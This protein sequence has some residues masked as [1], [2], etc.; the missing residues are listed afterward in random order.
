MAEAILSIEV[1]TGA[2][3]GLPVMFLTL[4]IAFGQH[5]SVQWHSGTDPM[6]LLR[7]GL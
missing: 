5:W 7:Q 4:Q 3:L 6:P 1:N 2:K